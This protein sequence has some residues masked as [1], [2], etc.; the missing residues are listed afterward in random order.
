[1]LTEGDIARIA[2]R[3]VKGYGPLAVGT[4]GSYATGR[5]RDSSD[6][7]I[8]VI[9]QTPE[10]ASARRRAVR[11]LLFGVLTALDIH[12]FAPEEFEEA[13]CEELSFE[14]IIARQAQLYYWSEEAR[15]RVPSLFSQQRIPAT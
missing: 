11:R 12:V 8:L 14:W 9:K 7:D 1:M 13:A 5:A 3:I 2:S 4:F 6:L 15:C 10:S